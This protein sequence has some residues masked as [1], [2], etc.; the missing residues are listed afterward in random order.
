ME[1]LE[2]PAIVTKPETAYVGI[3]VV[4]PFRGM[5]ATRDELMNEL[6]TWLDD[7]SAVD[8]GTLF[9]RL[10]VIDMEGPMDLEV[11]AITTDPLEGDDRVRA[12]VLP[13]GRYASLTYV[14]HARRANGA[15]LDWARDN[16]VTSGSVGRTDRRSLRLSVRGLPH[17]SALRAKEDEVAGG[18]QHPGGRR[19]SPR[20]TVPNLTPV[21]DRG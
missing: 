20:P 5:L 9:L 14:N 4:T 19:L 17:R 21:R 10:H 12:G 6:I 15:L 7:H 13:G 8:P 11:G 16:G 2:G 3:R 18:A 1:I